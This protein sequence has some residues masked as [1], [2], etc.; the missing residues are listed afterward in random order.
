MW[1]MCEGLDVCGR[2]DV[3]EGV[4]GVC[5]GAGHGEAQSHMWQ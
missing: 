1:G 5:V 4:G 3:C 2:Q